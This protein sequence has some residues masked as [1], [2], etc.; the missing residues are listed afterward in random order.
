[1]VQIGRDESHHVKLQ[2][3]ALPFLLMSVSFD[4]QHRE[5]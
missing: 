3:N 2:K 5:A 1:M 4:G